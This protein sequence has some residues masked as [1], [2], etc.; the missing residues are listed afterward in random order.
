MVIQAKEVRSKVSGDERDLVFLPWNKE[1][2][3]PSQINKAMHQYG[4]RQ[5]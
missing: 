5:K 2:L 3:C 1:Q 4:K